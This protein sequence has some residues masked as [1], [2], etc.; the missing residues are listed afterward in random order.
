MQV[1][2]GTSG[3]SYTAWRG[4]FY[5]DKLP[6]AKMLAFY[7]GKLGAVEINNTFYR[8]PNPSLLERWAAETPASFR[9]ALK[10]PR[11]ITHMKKLVDVA[12]AVA[13]LAEGARSLASRLGPILFQLPP[14]VRKDLGVLEAFLSTLSTQSTAT[15]G[16]RAA[17]EFR[18]ASWLADD[19]YDVLRRHDAALCVA[20]SEEFATPLEPTA[21]WGYLRL[22]RQDYDEAALRGWAERLRA[23]PFSETFVFFKHEDEGNGPRLAQRFLELAALTSPPA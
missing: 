13:K 21:G 22:R 3:F 20:D 2:T 5:P 18:H 12:D 6:E 10:S 19:T 17:V 14:F 15:K 7:A 23:Q 8:M 16:L 9:F 11:Q 4:S 1:L